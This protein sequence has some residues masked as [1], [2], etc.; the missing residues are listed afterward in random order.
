VYAYL[1]RIKNR[2][3]FQLGMN[4]SIVMGGILAFLT[5]VILILEFPFHISLVTI[6]SI[7]IGLVTGAI[8]GLL[9]DIPS[10]VAGLTNGLIMGL[11]SPVIGS[12]LEIQ[13]TFLWFIHGFYLLSL[14]TIFTSTKQPIN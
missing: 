4:I 1:S 6:C 14:L 11:V 13:Y 12:V 9:F 5:G 3:G 8:F 10:F 2:I 7:L